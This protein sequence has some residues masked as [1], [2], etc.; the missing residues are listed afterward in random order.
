MKKEDKKTMK[1]CN[2]TI[3]LLKNFSSVNP[4]IVLKKGSV[5]STLSN[6]KNI[7]AEA[8]I[9][10]KLPVDFAIYDLS[11]FLGAISL[12]DDPDFEFKDNHLIISSGKSKIKYF[13]GDPQG[14][15]TKTKSISMPKAEITFEFEKDTCES[16]MKAAGVL[17]VPDLCVSSVGGEDAPM[18][19]EVLDK[20]NASGNSFSV[21]VG[22][23]SQKFKMFFRV[24]NLKVIPGNY[25]VKISSQAISEFSSKTSK[26]CY[27]ISLEP[28][29]VFGE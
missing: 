1:I 18:N 14:I 7:L 23:S 19:L 10:E 8:T 11:E 26:I 29:S 5:I 3:S 9:S 15:V 6:G 21:A 28:D 12:F 22:K 4:S 17:Q 24:E 27:W 16:L 25:D 13:Y 20:K 2:E